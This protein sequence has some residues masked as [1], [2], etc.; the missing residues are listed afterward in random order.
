MKREAFGGTEH[1]K[2]GHL[3]RVA[4]FVTNRERKE[5]KEFPL[6]GGRRAL[7]KDVPNGSDKAWHQ[8]Q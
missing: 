5:K 1:G 8:K 6:K 3:I 2:G 4:E 7:K